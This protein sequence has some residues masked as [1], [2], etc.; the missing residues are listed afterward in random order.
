MNATELARPIGKRMGP[1][2]VIHGPEPFLQREAVRLIRTCAAGEAGFDVVDMDAKEVDPRSILDELRTPGLFAP[3]RLIIVE[4]GQFLLD[5]AP[6]PI[7]RYARQPTATTVLVLMAESLDSR[8]KEVKALLKEAV[9]VE[10][11]A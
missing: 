11:Q 7:L 4:N 10:C 3:G 1:I 5:R 8:K 9:V 6:E 2:Y